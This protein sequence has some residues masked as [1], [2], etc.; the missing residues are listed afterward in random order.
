MQVDFFN[1]GCRSVSSKKEFGICDDV[2]PHHSP[3][4]IKED[5]GEKWIAVVNNFYEEEIH[6]V[7]VDNC[8]PLKRKDGEDAQ[9]CDGFLFFNETIIFVELK[10]RGDKESRKWKNEATEQLKETI[11]LFEKQ[12]KAK[13][14]DTKMA[15]IANKEYPKPNVNNKNRAER[16]FDD[17]GYT[18]KIQNRINIPEDE[19]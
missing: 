16:F 9:K 13:Q 18:L 11:H 15:Y 12:E 2:P 19:N 6:F 10:V 8:I 5:E 4:Y 1:S 17:T 7:A 14:F 3:A